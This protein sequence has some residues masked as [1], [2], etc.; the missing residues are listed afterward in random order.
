M[1][2]IYVNNSVMDNDDSDIIKKT[3]EYLNYIDEHIRNV[4]SAYN[5]LFRSFKE[6][7]ANEI[8]IP[9]NNMQ[10]AKRMCNIILD[11]HDESKYEDEE[12][13]GYRNKYYMTDKEQKKYDNDRAYSKEVDENYEKAWEHHYKNNQHHPDYWLWVDYDP[14]G[15]DSTVK[16][17][18]I[19]RETPRSE[20][21][22]MPL[23]AVLEM[24]CDWEA[25]SMKF[26]N[27]LSDWYANN[28]DDEKKKLNP[29]TK[30]LVDK[31]IEWIKNHKE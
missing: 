2:K 26:N 7:D 12:F 15:N 11:S 6:E 9:Y 20:A 14:T 1:G 17:R 13:Y 25:M 5:N 27:K 19:H 18:Y 21:I 22:E 4:K 29:N 28:A 23:Y 8:G 10:S 30:D 31:F 24:L 16:G 3:K